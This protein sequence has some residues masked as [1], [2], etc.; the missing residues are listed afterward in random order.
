MAWVPP[1]PGGLHLQNSELRMMEGLESQGVGRARVSVR[2]LGVEAC[3]RPKQLEGEAVPRPGPVW[4][5]NIWC[6]SKAFSSQERN[7][8]EWG[9]GTGLAG[10]TLP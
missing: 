7:A 2:S 9:L 8:A 10:Q 3:L 4:P 6:E 5:L 1:S